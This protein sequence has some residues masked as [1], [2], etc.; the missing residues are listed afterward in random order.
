MRLVS[1]RFTY[2]RRLQQVLFAE[3]I[4]T[5]SPTHL[6]SLEDADIIQ[7]GPA[8]R[9]VSFVAPLYSW[10]IGYD[11][12][13]EIV[14]AQAISKHRSIRGRFGLNLDEPGG[15]DGRQSYIEKHWDGVFPLS[16]E[17]IHAGF[18][19]YRTKAKAVNKLLH[20]DALR[21]AWARALRKLPRARSFHFVGLEWDDH[22][23]NHLPIQPDCV[24][25]P[26]KHDGLHATEACVGALAV[27]CDA[28]FAAGIAC[29][30]EAGAEVEALK[31]AGPMTTSYG[32]EDLPG[33]KSLNLTHMRRFEFA[34]D[35]RVDCSR[36]YESVCDHSGEQSAGT[37]RATEATA[38]VM[39]K[40]ASHLE[41]FRYD[42]MKS[43]MLCP[44]EEIIPLPRL[45]RLELEY[46]TIKATS[47]KK[48]MAGMPSLE[49]LFLGTIKLHK[50]ENFRG[51]LKVFNA[52]RHHP[53]GMRVCFEE[54]A[55]SSWLELSIDYHTDD[56]EE[57]LEMAE[58]C[59]WLDVD[60]S[61]ALYLSGKGGYNHHMRDM[62]DDEDP[63]DQ[64]SENENWEDRSS[65]DENVED[66]NSVHGD[67]ANE[68][69]DGE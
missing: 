53:K 1:S 3:I 39:K 56:Y 55:V 30:S 37:R 34:P 54:I 45:L 9:E 47:F 28:I 23:G 58:G 12:F 69:S 51:W 24:V 18:Q 46:G 33:W 17:Q 31:V 32:W 16:E 35:N 36:Y 67:L 63:D 66:E 11:A 20:S 2:L 8:V 27:V 65:E 43:P 44:G 13:E 10:T 48:W 38:S 62:L 6:K 57:F 29:L 22:R 4:F 59:D 5:P 19:T 7:F 52:I 50:K 41:Y 64:I 49:E 26:H 61:L 15:A 21:V 68:G 25:R 60:R 42:G 14:I 40:S